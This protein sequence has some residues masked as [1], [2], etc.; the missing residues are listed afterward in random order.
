[1]EET[2]QKK[3]PRQPRQP[4]QPKPITEKRAQQNRLA[5][6]AFR[7]KKAKEFKEMQQKLKELQHLN[8]QAEHFEQLQQLTIQHELEMNALKQENLRL[9]QERETMIYA[10]DRLRGDNM[11]LQQEVQRL[12]RHELAPI[13]RK[14]QGGFHEGFVKG[15]GL[16]MV[17]R[18]PLNVD[19]PPEVRLPEKIDDSSS[20]HSIPT[21]SSASE[22]GDEKFKLP[23][24]SVVENFL[25][26]WT[27][28][29]P[30][31]SAQHTP[32]H[33]SLSYTS[34][35]DHMKTLPSID[36]NP[37]RTSTQSFDS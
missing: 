19:R 31:P 26:T 3:Q 15:Q 32:Y 18:P 8:E 30:K 28:S 12:R 23:K 33:L 2:E 6:K 10:M 7:E 13:K 14:P 20:P 11:Q 1:M 4:K 36:S 25:P 21:T 35:P 22:H 29:N 27:P 5:Q 24:V 16:G 9:F 34:T 17:T 37:P